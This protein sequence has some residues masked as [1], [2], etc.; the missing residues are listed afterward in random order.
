[1]SVTAQAGFSQLVKGGELSLHQNTLQAV[2]ITDLEEQLVAVTKRKTHEWKR[3][4]Q[5]GTMVY[6]EAANQVA[7]SMALVVNSPKKTYHGGAPEKV[8][9]TQ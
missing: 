7:A 4:H 3:I 6:S 8:L 5:G 2:W 1:L 9:S